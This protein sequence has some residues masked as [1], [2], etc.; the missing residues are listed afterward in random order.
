M[1][2]DVHV[3]SAIDTTLDRPVALGYGDVGLHVRRHLPR[4]L[5]DPPPMDGKVV[6]VTGAASGIGLA[7]C[8]GFAQLGASVRAI[9]RDERRAEDAVRQIREAAPTADARGLSCDVASLQALRSLA[10]RLS[11]EEE[12]LDVLV[13]SS[14]SALGACTPRAS[15][16]ET[17]NP[18]RPATRLR[19]RPAGP[20]P[21]VGPLPVA[22]RIVRLQRLEREQVVKRPLDEVFAF[23]ARAENLERITPPWL[24]FRVLTPGPIEMGS[25][26]MIDYRLRLHGLPLRWTSRIELW[27][28]TRRFIDQQVH[29]PYR[30]WRHLHEFVPVGRGACVRDRV[31]YALPLGWLGELL[32]LPVV[33]RDLVRIFDYR[34]AAVARMLG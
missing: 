6:V 33:R 34:R 28:D 5:A 4:W 16:T 3:T 18:R 9:A 20:S 21:A 15:R 14:T 19:R 17:S 26:T 8:R 13:N 11:A 1:V 29:G 23:F 25:G 2:S 22:D 12:Q 7:A 31:E 24:G 32:G 30:F 10:E 27:E